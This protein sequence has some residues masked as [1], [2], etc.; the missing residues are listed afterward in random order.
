[1]KSGL[2]CADLRRAFGPRLL[3]SVLL[4]AGQYVGNVFY[5][6]GQ[7]GVQA[8]RVFEDARNFGYYTWILPLLAAFPAATNF[9]VDWT[10]HF[11][12]EQM[13]RIGPRAYTM[14]KWLSSFLSGG[15]ACAAGLLL[16]FLTTLINGR[17][18]GYQDCFRA[19]GMWEMLADAHLALYMAG[20]LYVAFLSGGFYATCA[21]AF[22][23]YC[24][25]QYLTLCF[26]MLV[27]RLSY[28]VAATGTY[29]LW[30][31]LGMLESGAT[32]LGFWPALGVATAIFG[33]LSVLCCFI[34]RM[35]VERRLA[36]G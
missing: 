3:V 26:P 28:S 20:T 35:G 19:D 34:F 32:G 1:M 6:I 12:F 13:T 30:S 15:I 21:L 17:L 2:T 23:G 24:P 25:N 16:F 18:D 14:S 7:S 27:A 10:R 22:S 31:N 29:P 4:V 33:G 11:A 9:C 8:L 36:H 5:S